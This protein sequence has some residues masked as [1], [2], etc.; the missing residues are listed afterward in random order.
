MY[1]YQGAIAIVSLFSGQVILT[2]SDTY[3][4]TLI[5]Q[6]TTK[7]RTDELVASYRVTVACGLAFFVGVCQFLLVIS[8]LKSHFFS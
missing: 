6:N 3:E 7:N 5:S 1:Y 2:L 4:N 8:T